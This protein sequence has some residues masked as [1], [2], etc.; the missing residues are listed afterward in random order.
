MGFSR[1]GRFVFLEADIFLPQKREWQRV[2]GAVLVEKGGV[3]LAATR[4]VGP[5]CGREVVPF[6]KVTATD[7]LSVLAGIGRDGTVSAWRKTG[8]GNEYE[9]VFRRNDPLVCD[10]WLYG[11]RGELLVVLAIDGRMW[12]VNL[13]KKTQCWQASVNK[14]LVAWAFDSGS[15]MLAISAPRHGVTVYEVN[16]AGSEVVYRVGGG[17][18]GVQ[19]IC[20]S[21][22]LLAVASRTGQVR[23]HLLPDGRSTFWRPEG[24]IRS[25]SLVPGP[26]RKRV[27]AIVERPETADVFELPKGRHLGCIPMR[28]WWPRHGSLFFS[29]HWLAL[30][31]GQYAWQLPDGKPAPWNLPWTVPAFRRPW[32]ERNGR[33]FLTTYGQ[34]LSPRAAV[35]HGWWYEPLEGTIEPVRSVEGTDWMYKLAPSG[36]RA[37]V[38]A[39]SGTYLVDVAPSPPGSARR[40]LLFG[41]EP[42]PVEYAWVTDRLVLR[43]RRGRRRHYFDLWDVTGKPRRLWSIPAPPHGDTLGPFEGYV[44]VLDRRRVLIVSEVGIGILDFA[45]KRVQWLLRDDRRQT[46]YWSLAGDAEFAVAANCVVDPYGGMLYVWNLKTRTGVSYR[47]NFG[48]WCAELDSKAGYLALRGHDGVVRLW[49]LR[50][51]LPLSR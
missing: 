25:V 43:W 47:L 24:P 10:L 36:R 33:M 30:I 38:W 40:L 39:K 6:S 46:H 45:E 11:P 17:R 22:G 8:A 49:R 14:P 23:L 50:R 32:G 21:S 35:A 2:H 13:D 27:I 41:D 18:D 20:L 29:R 44:H 51:L 1:R 15:A 34:V 28:G 19:S 26:S 4:C 42:S 31:S 16:R 5:I 7:D 37:L 48:V 9:L 3:D 12:C